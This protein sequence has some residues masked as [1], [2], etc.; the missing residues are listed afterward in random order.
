MSARL[1]LVRHGQ[2]LG[3]LGGGRMLVGRTDLPMT[4]TGVRQ[5]RRAARRLRRVP[6]RAVHSSPL[7]RAVATAREIVALRRV[8]L[9]LWDDLREIDCGDADGLETETARRLYP[10]Y[11]ERNERQDDD[12]F[13]W[14][15][16]E[17]YR[18]L[19]RRAVVAC[20]RL[21]REHAGA[22]AVV[23]THA[24]VVSQLVGAIRGFRPACWT[25]CR[26]SHCTVTEL[27]W[28]GGTRRLVRFDAPLPG[29][30][31]EPAALEPGT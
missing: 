12:D 11:W 29:R 8:P 16:G 2:T 5:A 26:P 1:L 6:F 25:R 31:G 3:N 23:V 15:G 22:T 24:G 13:R 21:A 20:D 19:R 4:V 30:G 27:E 9:S 7:Q 10:D 17:S 18:E 14:P 28:G